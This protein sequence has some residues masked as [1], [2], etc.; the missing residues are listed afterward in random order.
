M[1]IIAKKPVK[2]LAQ[3]TAERNAG[4]SLSSSSSN[5]TYKPPT[6]TSSGGSSSSSSS[7]SSGIFG[8]IAGALG[9]SANK[10]TNT[11]K[12][13]SSS[14]QYAPG[15]L[16]GMTGSFNGNNWNDNSG[17]L[18]NG[19]MQTHGQATAQN[20][21]HPVNGQRE[22]LIQGAINSGDWQAYRDWSAKQTPMYFDK[23]ADGKNTYNK[24]YYANLLESNM[25]A[26]N[27]AKMSGDTFTAGEWE[28]SMRETLEKYKNAPGIDQY[29][30]GLNNTAE[31]AQQYGINQAG[32]DYFNSEWNDPNV[33]SKGYK[34]DRYWTENPV[35]ED[36]NLLSNALNLSNQYGSAEEQ[37]QRQQINNQAMQSYYQGDIQSQLQSEYDA[38]LQAQLQAQKEA[39][40]K[41]LAELQA[42]QQ[43]NEYDQSQI[44]NIGGGGSTTTA[45]IGNVESIFTPGASSNTGGYTDNQLVTNDA[46][47]RFLEG[48]YQGG[49]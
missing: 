38:Q 45:P 44:G 14:S 41:M 17:V 36:F 18:I 7:S 20:P 19:Q 33:R 13:G 29:I 8:S 4:S 26:I 37:A 49:F 10:V 9:G 30:I 21:L 31:L 2:S 48:I 16:A 23:G 3:I 24:N 22:N 34:E 25:R 1:V 11:T 27:E 42:Q 6:S 46:Y 12:P 5:S 35:F 15:A 47:K 43:K 39:Y 40:E 28:R 32:S